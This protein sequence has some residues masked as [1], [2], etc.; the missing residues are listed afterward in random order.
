M[1]LGLQSWIDW[2]ARLV[3]VRQTE[4][5]VGNLA[6]SLMQDTENTIEVADIALVSLV[7]QFEM[8]TT[9]RGTSRAWIRPL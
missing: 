5:A 2:Q 8:G 3:Q 7:A 9:R 1:T 6:R 4:V